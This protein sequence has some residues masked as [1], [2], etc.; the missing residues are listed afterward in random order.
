MSRSMSGR[1]P[2]GTSSLTARRNHLAAVHRSV[3]CLGGWE[4]RAAPEGVPIRCTVQWSVPAST[5]SLRHRRAPRCRMPMAGWAERGAA[6][7]LRICRF[8]VPR[9][10]AVGS[11]TC[12]VKV[13]EIFFFF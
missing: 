4:G 1:V 2:V 3:A 10:G 12:Q 5:P 8:Y 9:T 11:R 7:V 13:W 6:E